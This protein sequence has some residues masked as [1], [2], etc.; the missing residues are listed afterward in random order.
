MAKSDEI[1][2]AVL[3]NQGT[4]HELDRQLYGRD[5]APGDIPEIKGKLDALNGTVR[6]H[7]KYIAIQKDRGSMKTRTKIAGGSGVVAM[8]ASIAYLVGQAAGVW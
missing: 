1:L 4:L 7:D 2:K 5:G 3:K 8:I 6:E